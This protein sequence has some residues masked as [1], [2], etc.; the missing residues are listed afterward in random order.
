MVSHHNSAS[1]HFAQNVNTFEAQTLLIMGGYLGLIEKKPS[2]IGVLSFSCISSQDS[3]AHM[4]FFH[5]GHVI[6]EQLRV[7]V[8][9]VTF[10]KVNSKNTRSNAG[11]KSK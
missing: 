9:S 1:T 3:V 2:C 8:L 4:S 10:Y 6:P 5:H 11:C 7:S